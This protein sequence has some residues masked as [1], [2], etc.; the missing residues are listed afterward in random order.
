MSMGQRAALSAVCQQCQCVLLMH[1]LADT[2]R[3]HLLP[4]QD[5]LSFLVMFK[6]RLVSHSLLISWR[7]PVHTCA[8][9]AVAAAVVQAS[10]VRGLYILCGQSMLTQETGTRPDVGKLSVA[11]LNMEAAPGRLY[12]RAA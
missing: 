11:S 1:R 3:K 8:V 5:N 6:H 10:I 4:R 12:D 7:L 9:S 2:A